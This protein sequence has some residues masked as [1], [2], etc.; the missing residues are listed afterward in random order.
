MPLTHI[1]FSWRRHTPGVQSDNHTPSSGTGTVAP[2]TKIASARSQRQLAA[3]VG[4]IPEKQTDIGNARRLGIKII[5]V[6]ALKK[7]LGGLPALPS[8]QDDRIFTSTLKSSNPRIQRAD[9][10]TDEHPD[11]TMFQYEYVK[12]EDLSGLYRPMYKEFKPDAT[13]N[14]TMPWLNLSSPAGTC[15]FAPVKEM[16]QVRKPRL[17]KRSH[18]AKVRSTARDLKGYCECCCENYS[19]GLLEHRASRKHQAFANNAAN[20]A[21]LD[22]YIAKYDLSFE[23]YLAKT[24]TQALIDT[25]ATTAKAA[26]SASTLS[27]STVN[28]ASVNER[29]SMV[30][31]PIKGDLKEVPLDVLTSETVPKS[32]PKATSGVQRCHL[33]APVPA[34]CSDSFASDDAVEIEPGAKEAESIDDKDGYR[35]LLDH[36]SPKK[37]TGKARHGDGDTE[38]ILCAFGDIRDNDEQKLEEIG[39]SP[40]LERTRLARES[41]PQGARRDLM[42]KMNESTCVSGSNNGPSR[43]H[44]KEPA[45]KKS[46]TAGNV[47]VIS[48]PSTPS[49][50]GDSLLEFAQ[51]PR[52]LSGRMKVSVGDSD[53]LEIVFEDRKGELVRLGDYV[54]AE[55]VEPVPSRKLAQA[56]EKGGQKAYPGVIHRVC[57]GICSDNFDI[58]RACDN[59]FDYQGLRSHK[60]YRHKCSGKQE[61]F[62]VFDDGDCCWVRT[63]VE[64]K[65]TERRRVR[66]IAGP[67]SSAAQPYPPLTVVTQQ[68]LLASSER[69]TS[70]VCGTNKRCASKESVKTMDDASTDVLTP[71][72][73]SLAKFR[74]AT[75]SPPTR[76]GKMVPRRSA[77]DAGV[78]AEDQSSDRVKSRRLSS[79]S[80]TIRSARSIEMKL[81]EAQHRTPPA[82]DGPSSQEP[83]RRT[84]RVRAEPTRFVAVSSNVSNMMGECIAQTSPSYQ[85]ATT[86]GGDGKHRNAISAIDFG[87]GLLATPEGKASP[88][89][90][91][92]AAKTP[93]IETDRTLQNDGD[94]L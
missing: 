82:V 55:Y 18:K 78:V 37:A 24:R 70:P 73:Q 84:Q 8:F 41:V 29:D 71:P 60:E 85:Q 58:E 3:A 14:S 21:V 53:P 44:G 62:V 69:V 31:S 90:V 91:P 28:I 54:Q 89:S 35:T 5:S 72:K 6:D 87:P 67:R 11:V 57:H 12:V 15:P 52:R 93:G 80:G 36:Y 42:N 77:E 81:E 63:E 38:D 61:V 46:I 45:G 74:L 16:Q 32:I 92:K 25:A 17:E 22:D 86:R 9:K 49:R 4:S 68:V 2:L 65:K 1:C 33:P 10:L 13:G 76:T 64:S 20:Y 88:R 75:D 83:T 66:K 59:C 30:E 51:L 79:G 47:T 19:S 34:M 23:S 48:P 50:S 94:L 39:L 26:K 43:R 7:Y 56:S 40:A 27:A